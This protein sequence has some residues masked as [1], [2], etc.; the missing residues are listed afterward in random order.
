MSKFW[1]RNMGYVIFR[2]EVFDVNRIP[3]W[4]LIYG[5]RKVGKTFLVRR[6]LSYDRYFLVRRDLTIVDEG[7]ARLAYTD[8]VGKVVKF[9]KSGMTVVVDEFQRLP[10][11]FMDEVVLAHPSGRLILLGSSLRLVH[12]VFSTGSPL[13]GLVTPFRLDLIRPSDILLSLVERIGAVESI[14]LCPFLREPWIIKYIDMYGGDSSRFVYEILRLNFYTVK[15]LIG[16]VFR[17]EE[18]ELTS[19]YEAI[20][21]IVASGYWKV[22]DIAAILYGRG[23]IS[24]PDTG[25]VRQYVLNLAHMGLIEIVPVVNM[26]E[27]YVKLASP[28]MDLYFF[29]DDRYNIEEEGMPSFNEVKDVIKTR[30]CMYVQDFIAKLYSQMLELKLN[31]YISP[32]VEIDF[33]LTKRRRI[34][35]VGEVKWRRKV[36]SR[37]VALFSRKCLQIPSR[38]RL[39]IAKG[40]VKGAEDIDV[41][42]PEDV[43][44]DTLQWMRARY[45]EYLVLIKHERH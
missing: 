31:Y 8:F 28:I 34:E 29:M 10:L 20:L 25:L 27:K 43:V 19:R 12:R 4:L 30:L 11:S 15:S 37:D 38:R 41:R 21:S 22:K 16:E 7:G 1:L 17:E 33:V 36:G 5:R 14:E 6:F 23:L 13:L 3:G 26:R 44:K 18:R 42:A 40:K 35:V 45:P 32:R 39:F 9:L 24:R 2:T